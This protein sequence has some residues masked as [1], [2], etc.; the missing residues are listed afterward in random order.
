MLKSYLF[1]I[2]ILKQIKYNIITYEIYI[3][4][5]ISIDNTWA[6]CVDDIVNDD[7]I[8]KEDYIVAY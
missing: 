1:I 2:I 5:F 6:K 3:I 8:P 7:L 4:K